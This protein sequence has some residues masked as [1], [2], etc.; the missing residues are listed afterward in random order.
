MIVKCPKCGFSQPQ[1]Q[2]CAQCG[3]DMHGFKPPKEPAVNR[4]AKDPI[5]HLS[6]VLI[7]AC[8]VLVTLYQKHLWRP[9][10]SESRD[11][12]FMGWQAS[13]SS[14]SSEEQTLSQAVLSDVESETPGS[15]LLEE[16][17]TESASMKKPKTPFGI[18]RS[19]DVRNYQA[20]LSYAEV[21]PRVLEEW[22]EE[23]TNLGQ[24]N[25]FGDYGAGLIPDF[26]EKLKQQTKHYKIHRTDSQS[27]DGVQSLVSQFQ[28]PGL[29]EEGAREIREPASLPDLGLQSQIVIESIENGLSKGHIELQRLQKDPTTGQIQKQIY[30]AEFELS[31][32]QA[33][34][35]TG[36]G[37]SGSVRPQESEFIIW[38]QVDKA[39]SP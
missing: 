29:P 39:E 1:D 7:V 10:L 35:V 18:S 17:A 4:W 23:A 13:T 5:V 34:I 2:Y 28:W 30:P 36:I 37:P 3:V 27:L 31:Q 26:K 19:A 21:S 22:I 16:S 14:K 12:N 9:L 11:V 6:L 25:S 20:K 15:D 24:F 33:F 8:V 38:I 32:N